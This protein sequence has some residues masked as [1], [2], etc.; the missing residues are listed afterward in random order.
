RHKDTK[1]RRP[2]IKNFYSGASVFLCL[3]VFLVLIYA[4]P[5]ALCSRRTGSAVGSDHW[6][7]RGSTSESVAAIGTKRANGLRE[8]H[9]IAGARYIDQRQYDQPD[10]SG[11]SSLRRQRPRSSQCSA[12][13]HVVVS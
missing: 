1:A 8:S 6:P 10:S 7:G 12:I 5:S 9:S 11:A 3:C 13:R 2:A 4:A